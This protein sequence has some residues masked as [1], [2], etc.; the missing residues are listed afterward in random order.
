MAKKKDFSNIVEESFE[1]GYRSEPEA[2]VSEPERRQEA[3]VEEPVTV[4]PEH[5]SE[6]ELLLKKINSGDEEALESLWGREDRSTYYLTDLHRACIDIMSH[7]EGIKKNEVIVSALNR[8]FP[9]TVRTAAKELIVSRAIK[10]LEKDIQK[11][12]EGK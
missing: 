5:L 4:E 7:E 2:V 11:E 12:K 9:E 8:F 3:P 1:E 10:K 6:N